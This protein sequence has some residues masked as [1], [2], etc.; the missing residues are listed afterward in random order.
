M[1]IKEKVGNLNSFDIRHR[2]VDRLALEWYEVNKRILHKQTQSGREV[3]IKFMT[4]MQSLAEDDVLWYDD[5]SAIVVDIQPCEAICI[6]PASR[7]DIAAVCYEIGNKHLPLFYQDD[8]LLVP[9]EA[10]LFK[11]LSAGGY[12]VKRERRK[13]LNQIRT[14]VAPH[15]KTENKQSMFSKIIQLTTSSGD[16]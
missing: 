1:L 11:M 16:A 10:P 8:E 7:K 3:V 15:A 6:R 9:F 5:T 12:Q 2:S 13:L 4:E 14:T